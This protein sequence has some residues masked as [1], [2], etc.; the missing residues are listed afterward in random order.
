[1][2][3]TVFKTIVYRD[4]VFLFISIDTQYDIIIYRMTNAAVTFIKLY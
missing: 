2:Y 1:M 3:S 4:T